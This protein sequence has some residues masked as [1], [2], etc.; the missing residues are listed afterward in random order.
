MAEFKKAI[1]KTLKPFARKVGADISAI[2]SM[3]S[4]GDKVLNVLDHGVDNT[5]STDVSEKLTELFTKAHDENYTKVVFPDGI[6]KIDSY[7]ELKAYEEDNK[8]I[9]VQSLNR[10]GATFKITGSNNIYSGLV[11][12]PSGIETSAHNIIIDGFNFELA[13]Q[14]ITEYQ[15]TNNACG[16]SA[17]SNLTTVENCIFENLKFTG[18]MYGIYFGIDIINCTIYNTN[19]S[20]QKYSISI[21]N[22]SKTINNKIDTVHCNN[23]EY[24]INAYIRGTIQNIKIV[25]DK[26][27]NFNASVFGAFDISN[28]KIK[29]HALVGL[30]VLQ[31]YSSTNSNITGIYLDIDPIIDESIISSYASGKTIPAF[32]DILGNTVYEKTPIYI[33]NLTVELFDEKYRSILD[34]IPMFAYLNT[35]VPIVLTD[36]TQYENLKYFSTKCAYSESTINGTV[37]KSFNAINRHYSSRPFV[38]LDRN[39]SGTSVALS[40]EGVA[41]YLGS[42]GTPKIDSL[43]TDYS[44]NT[45]GIKGDIFTEVEPEK[46]G[47]FAYVSTYEHISP[48]NVS[49]SDIESLT[50]NEADNTYTFK[51]N[52]MPVWSNGILKGMQIN[53]G[54]MFTDTYANIS[55]SIIEVNEIAK[56]FKTKAY[57]ESKKGYAHPY[58]LSSTTNT[59]G[60]FG[61]IMNNVIEPYEINRMKNMTY[62]TVPIIHSGDTEHRPT[63]NLV[64]GQ[65]YFD[66]TLGTPVFWNGTEWIKGSNGAEI[67]TSTLA[68]KAELNAIPATNIT[69]DNNHYFVTGDQQTKLDSLYNRSEFDS[70]FTKK[71]EMSSYATKTEMQ[72]AIAAIPAPTVDTSNLVTKE[73][74]NTMLNA[75]NEKLKQIRGE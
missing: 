69:Q 43:G 68:T 32:I 9:C 11:I 58:V 13:E 72:Q 34:R 1:E 60:I 47:H 18:G 75:I 74:L 36:T 30:S 55:F 38:G 10:Y 62:V 67:D 40:N 16:I 20:E 14:Q 27:E 56:T 37:N 51:F 29:A 53:T 54:S 71:S 7:V 15:K 45:A 73:E 66:T 52:K 61:S 46:N 25:Y 50:Y 6:Y 42:R 35:Q 5:G 39:M 33:S 41:I 17:S 28:I 3:I 12:S 23:V 59:D 2:K 4:R 24:G 8:A 31:I 49:S 63:E 65:M 26:T 64:I 19:H 22:N 44:E 57:P 70:L 48:I 21:A